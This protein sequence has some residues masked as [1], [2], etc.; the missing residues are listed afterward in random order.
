MNRGEGVRVK[1]LANMEHWFRGRTRT[2]DADRASGDVV[3]MSAR[4]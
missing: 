1:P 3:Q 2:V 4:R